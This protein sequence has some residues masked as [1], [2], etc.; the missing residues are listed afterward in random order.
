MSEQNIKSM[1]LYDQ[2]DRIFNDLRHI[3]IE[4]D[5]PLTVEDLS[6]FDQYHY[7][8]T[9]AVDEAIQALDIRE[10]GTVLD[11]GSGLGGPARYMAHRTG[12][13]VTALELQPDL[14]RVA[15]SLTRRC[16]LADRVDHVCANVLTAN[17]PEDGHDAVVSWLVFYH[18][19]ERAE[20]FSRCF[21]ALRG[22]G[23]LY[24]EDLFRHGEFS[25]EEQFVVT[26]TIYGQCLPL[27]EEYIDQLRSAGFE[28]IRFTDLTGACKAFVIDRLAQFRGNRSRHLSVHGP[29]IV[30][31]LDE[32]YDE[33]VKLFEGGKLGGVRLTARK[34]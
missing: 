5:A 28:D 18:I 30:A 15:A 23:A 1:K 10:A 24:T 7:F 19:A 25:R 32:F 29:D 11:I 17:L 4:D 2:V 16:G 6:P 33:V 26:E 21:R 13:R 34:P 20:L 9:D 3:G 31:A 22:G 14:H 8:G 12:C 27:R